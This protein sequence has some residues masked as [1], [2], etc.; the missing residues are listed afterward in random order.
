MVDR[1]F[2]SEKKI[3]YRIALVAMV[4]C[5]NVNWHVEESIDIYM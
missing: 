4:M 2:T 1:V 3:D 5:F